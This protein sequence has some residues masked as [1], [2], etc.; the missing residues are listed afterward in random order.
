MRAALLIMVIGVTGG[1]GG[2]GGE[3][4]DADTSCRESWECTAWEVV[5]GATEAT[6][7]CTDANM[8]G[9]TECKPS[10]GPVAL[11]VLDK[12]M[13][14]C[15]VHPILQRGCAQQGCHG[16]ETGRAL[17]IYAR[18]RLRNSQTVNRTGTC[19]PANGTVNLDE[20]GTGTVMCEG[21]LPHTTEEWQKSF[22]S[23]R[24]FMLDVTSADQSP[25]LAEPTVG[26]PAHAGIKM[27][28]TTDVDYQTIKGWLAGDKLG[29][30]CVT[31]KN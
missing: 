14:K 11:P 10:L 30:T 29:T 17:R 6:R 25:L 4:A 21:W 13:Y 22:D 31:G 19:I 8:A 7:T 26:G 9:T 12:E 23:A 18:G 24:S 16:T 28:R 1:C 15:R 2:S 3:P 5:P 27:F 20:E